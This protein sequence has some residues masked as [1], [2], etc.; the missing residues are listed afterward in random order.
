M[1]LEYY[2][3]EKTFAGAIDLEHGKGVYEPVTQKGALG[4]DP[5]EPRD[6]IILKIKDVYKRQGKDSSGQSCSLWLTR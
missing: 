6:E 5:K 2:K 4:H 1:Q 3:L